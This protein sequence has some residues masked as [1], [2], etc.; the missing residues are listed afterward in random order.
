MLRIKTNKQMLIVLS[1]ILGHMIYSLL[2]KQDGSLWARKL[3]QNLCTKQGEESLFNLVF[4][5]E[6]MKQKKDRSFLLKSNKFTGTILD[7]PSKGQLAEYDAG[8]Y[9]K[10]CLKQTL[11]K[12]DQNQ[13]SRLIIA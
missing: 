1:Y 5:G 10:T 13:F 6:E 2:S 4:T 9:N 8:T 12:E 7:T 11:K 3:R